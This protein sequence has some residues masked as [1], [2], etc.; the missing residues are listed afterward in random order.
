ML[1]IV[2]ERER[3]WRVVREAMPA[4]ARGRCRVERLSASCVEGTGPG[5]FLNVDGLRE[6]ALV[7]DEGAL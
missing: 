3:M 4:S 6:P 5:R 1:C 7:C 2:S